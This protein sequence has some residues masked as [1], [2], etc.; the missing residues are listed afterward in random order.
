MKDIC[1]PFKSIISTGNPQYNGGAQCVL[2]GTEYF[3]IPKAWVFIIIIMGSISAFP[4]RYQLWI[5][6]FDPLTLKPLKV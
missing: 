5:F 6:S 2:W 4:Q 1:I 3:Q